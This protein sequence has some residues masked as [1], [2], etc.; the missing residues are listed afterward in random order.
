MKCRQYGQVGL[1]T[2]PKGH[3]LI[4]ILFVGIGPGH[5]NAVIAIS[6]C[7][8]ALHCTRNLMRQGLGL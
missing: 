2:V 8:L 5:D 3:R 1:F 7:S 6:Q 4:F